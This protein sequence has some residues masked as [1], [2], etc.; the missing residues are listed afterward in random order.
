MIRWKFPKQ[1]IFETKKEKNMNR[2]AALDT[3]VAPA[4][5]VVSV[6]PVSTS[7]ADDEIRPTTQTTRGTCYDLSK[8][9]SE[10]FGG[11]K[12][13]YGRVFDRRNPLLNEG[14]WKDA[15]AQYWSTVPAAPVCTATVDKDGFKVVKHQKKP[16]TENRTNTMDKAL[17]MSWVKPRVRA[18]LEK[19]VQASREKSEREAQLLYKARMY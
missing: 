15:C 1:L 10:A 2:F 3:E 5:P 13:I 11:D 16:T 8:A 9:V 4:T 17:A 6:T 7:W 18:A 12:A 19:S 14:E